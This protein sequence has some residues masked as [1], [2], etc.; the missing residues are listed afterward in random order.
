MTGMEH[1]DMRGHSEMREEERPM[2]LYGV[3]RGEPIGL[4]PRV[5][6]SGSE[7]EQTRAVRQQME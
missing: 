7:E 5:I 4:R 3:M 6:S 2:A 1:H